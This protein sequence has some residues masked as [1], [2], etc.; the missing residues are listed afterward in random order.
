MKVIPFERATAEDNYK[1]PSWWIN[2]TADIEPYEFRSMDSPKRRKLRVA[3]WHRDINAKLFNYGGQLQKN[4]DGNYILYF[5]ID[6]NYTYFLLKY[7]FTPKESEF[8][9]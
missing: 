6:S 1:A 4:K 5:R 2:F 9:S 3:E 7:E 8:W